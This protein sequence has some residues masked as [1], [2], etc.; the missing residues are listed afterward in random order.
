MPVPVFAALCPD[1]GAGLR[2]RER[3]RDSHRFVGCSAWPDCGFCCDLLPGPDPFRDEVAAALRSLVLKWH[4]DH[5]RTLTPH[6][7]VAELNA[8][9]DFVTAHGELERRS[10]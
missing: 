10:A 6:Q 9:R 7:V 1:C 5:C 4:P 3:R 2:I 8:L